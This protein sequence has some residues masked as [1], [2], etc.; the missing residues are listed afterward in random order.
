M[1][2]VLDNVKENAVI[3]LFILIVFLASIYMGISERKLDNEK[4]NNNPVILN[5]Q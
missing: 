1:V 4:V 2:K 5:I 3:I